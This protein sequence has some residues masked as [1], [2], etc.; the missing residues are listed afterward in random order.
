MAENPNTFAIKIDGENFSVPGPTVSG[1]T[2]KACAGKDAIY[3]IIMEGKAT[4]PDLIVAD[5][6]AVT[7]E[8]GMEFYTVPP[9]MAGC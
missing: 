4:A 7:L 8:N 6:M 1:A 3:Q 2:L 9:A 5:H